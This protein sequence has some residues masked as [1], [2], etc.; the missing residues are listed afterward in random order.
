MGSRCS[1]SGSTTIVP[2]ETYIEAGAGIAVTGLGT[3]VSPFIVKR[4][5]GDIV[6]VVQAPADDVVIGDGQYMFTVPPSLATTV[7][8]AVNATVSGAASSSGAIDVQVSRRRGGSTVDVL[9]TKARIDATELSSSTGTPGVPN[10]SN[11]DLNAF[12]ILAVDV[13]AAGTD[14]KGLHVVISYDYE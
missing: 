13:D 5:G 8:T 1:C 9:T 14:A 6:L 3:E 12:D 4:T 10:T 11:D 2:S 7:I